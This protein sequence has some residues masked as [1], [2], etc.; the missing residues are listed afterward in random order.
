MRRWEESLSIAWFLPLRSTLRRKKSELISILKELTD[1]LFRKDTLVVSCTS[2]E[3]GVQA[4][5]EPMKALISELKGGRQRGAG[6]DHCSG[7]KK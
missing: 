6:A 3:E 5:R 2:E 4:V 7:Q 1:C